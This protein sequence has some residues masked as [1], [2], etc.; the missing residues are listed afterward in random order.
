LCVGARPQKATIA[1]QASEFLS[2]NEINEINI[3][4]A[5]EIASEEL[6]FGSNMRA[7]RDYRKAMSK[8]LLKRAI[9]EVI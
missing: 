5:V 4:K 3:D 8:V 2:N 9:M 6:T 1:K 7:S